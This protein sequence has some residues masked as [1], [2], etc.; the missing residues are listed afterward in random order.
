MFAAILC[1]LKSGR[2]K[3]QGA[4]IDVVK[5]SAQSGES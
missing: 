2:N 4:I 1:N 3:K 5:I